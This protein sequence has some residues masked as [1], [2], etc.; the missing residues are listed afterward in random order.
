MYHGVL[1]GYE[2]R[3]ADF[4]CRGLPAQFDDR[5]FNLMVLKPSGVKAEPLDV[6]GVPDF[7]AQKLA[8]SQHRDS[9]FCGY[10]PSTWRKNLPWIVVTGDGEVIENDLVGHCARFHSD[11][12]HFA[13]QGL[14]I[15]F[16]EQ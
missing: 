6:Q 7:P 13:G 3:V 9:D 11:I 12:L 10:V 4:C 5:R 14:S 16:I 2:E 1:H 8:S 15:R